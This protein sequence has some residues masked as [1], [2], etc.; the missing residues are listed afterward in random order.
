MIY[1]FVD[2]GVAAGHP[3]YLEHLLSE[4]RFVSFC[5]GALLLTD[6]D[7]IVDLEFW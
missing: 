5:E 2:V 4:V 7:R 6:A 3:R 1:E